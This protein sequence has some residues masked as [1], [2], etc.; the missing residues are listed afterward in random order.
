M[1]KRSP[2]ARPHVEP[3]PRVPA[4]PLAS[5]VLAECRTWMTEQGYAQG[6]ASNIVNLLARLSLWM[7]TESADI[8]D[9]CEELLDRFVD[10][11]RSRPVVVSSLKTCMATLRKFLVSADYL[12]AHRAE[13]SV[14]TEAQRAVAQW[15]A[16]MHGERGLQDKTI[17]AHCYYSAGLVDLLTTDDG[18]VQWFRLEAPLINAYVAERGRT[19]GVVA[20]THIVDRVAC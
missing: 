18:M 9:I 2:T 17:Q 13:A 19:Y 7:Q 20:R 5:S 1:T 8:D 16:W 14:A 10:F 15:C 12:A 6:S 3:I 4:G 11:E